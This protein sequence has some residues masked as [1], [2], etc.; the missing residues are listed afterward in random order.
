MNRFSEGLSRMNLSDFAP[1]P[2]AE[3]EQSDIATSEDA[4]VSRLRPMQDGLDLGVIH[5]SRGV[6][7]FGGPT[8]A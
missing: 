1:Y 6:S 8:P 4:A 5:R 3:A 7:G 2:V